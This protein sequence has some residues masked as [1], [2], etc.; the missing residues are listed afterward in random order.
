MRRAIFGRVDFAGPFDGD[1][2]RLRA[3]AIILGMRVYIILIAH[4]ISE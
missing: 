3:I 2:L 1:W 4:T